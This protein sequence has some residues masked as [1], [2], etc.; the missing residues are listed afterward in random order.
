MVKTTYVNS[1]HFKIATC[2]LKWREYLLLF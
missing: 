2:I 1:I